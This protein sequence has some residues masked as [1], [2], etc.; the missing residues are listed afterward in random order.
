MLGSKW[1]ESAVRIGIV[2]NEHEVPNF[3]ALS[4]IGVDEIAFAV[5]IGGKVD[6]QF[7]ARTARAGVAHHPKIIFLV[8][9]HYMHGGI[10]A[11]GGENFSPVIVSLLIKFAR[12]T[13][14]GPVN[15][16]I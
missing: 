9:V 13:F 1:W 7:T 4:A 2:L 11:G 6:M 8:A 15:G 16:C 12:I 14:S 3:D 5:A 10:K